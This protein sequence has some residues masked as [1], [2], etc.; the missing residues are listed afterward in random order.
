M[1]KHVNDMM[2][3]LS[4]AATKVSIDRSCI[5][6]ARAIAYIGGRTIYAASQQAKFKAATPY[7]ALTPRPRPRPLQPSPESAS[8]VV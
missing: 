1:D 2:A 8:E 6:Q 5:S 4:A 7:F 3:M